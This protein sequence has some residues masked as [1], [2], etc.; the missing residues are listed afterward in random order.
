MVLYGEGVGVDGVEPLADPVVEVDVGDRGD[1]RHVVG[2]HREVV[3][4]AGD[5]DPAGGHL[6]HRMVGAVVSEGQLDRR[7]AEGRGQQLMAQADAEHGNRRAEQP[8][9]DVRGCVDARWIPWSVGEEDAVGLAG[10]RFL[11]RGRRRHDVDRSERGE[12]AQ[13]RALD[14]IVVGDDAARRAVGSRHRVRLGRRDRGDEVDPVGARFGCGGGAHCLAVVRG[15][16]GARHRASRADQAGQPTRVDA[17]DPGDAV[18]PQQRVEVA[19]GA[20]VG[21]PPGEIADH[22][23]S[24][25]QTTGLEVGG[26]DPVVTDVRV[27][28][29]DDLTGVARVGEHLLIAAEGRVEHDFSCGGGNLGTEQLPF[30]LRTVRQDQDARTHVHAGHC[31]FIH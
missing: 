19:L 14:A 29:R 15:T 10:Q 28:E 20:P 8:G 9:D 27:G 22:D 30:E 31:M 2:G 23:A 18:Q 16:E 11:G 3:V 4:L 17:G 26:V 24:A 7:A 12:V 25:E 1:R 6:L 13:D 21:V 5:L